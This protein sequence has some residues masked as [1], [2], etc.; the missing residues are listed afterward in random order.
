M[1]QREISVAVR[2]CGMGVRDSRQ[3]SWVRPVGRGREALEWWLGD[4]RGRGRELLGFWGGVEGGGAV[5]QG[6]RVR[7]VERERS[8]AVV[9]LGG[10]SAG[11]G[12]GAA[13]GVKLTEMDRRG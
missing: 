1:R 4:G 2:A 13:L 7:T 5:I 10:R 3:A 8:G 12:E 9:L 11:V 6:G